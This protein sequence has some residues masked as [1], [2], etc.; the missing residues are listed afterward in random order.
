MDGEAGRVE[1]S[2]RD[3][4]SHRPPTVAV[5]SP[6]TGGFYFGGILTGIAREVAASGGRVVLLQTLDAGRSGDE[7]LG[8]PDFSTPSA[9]DH[10][11]GVIALAASVR[12]PF[13]EDLRARGLAVVT[14]GH[15]VEGFPARSAMPD[16]A[17]GVRAAVE[18]LVRAHGHTRIGF[19]G[20]LEQTD[21]IE[22]FTA[23]Q[24]TLR[25]HGIEPDPDHYFPASN[26]AEEGGRSAAQQ[27]VAAGAPVTAV[28]VATDRNALGLLSVLRDSTDDAVRGL[29][30]V[31][32]DD[33]EAWSTT[34]PGL[35]TVDQEFAHVG[36]VAARVLLA[37]LRGE[38]LPPGRQV[39]PARLVVRTSCGCPPPGT[40][41]PDGHV[42][43]GVPVPGEPA[44]APLP[45]RDRLL[46]RLHE[47]VAP[48]RDTFEA[49]RE[50]EAGA[51]A[52]ARALDAALAEDE[53]AVAAALDEAVS[54]LHAL[55]PTPEALQRTVATV[56]DHVEELLDD[57]A[58]G[59]DAAAQRALRGVV[60]RATSAFWVAHTAARMERAAVLEDTIAEQY[61]VGM[62]LLDRR[63]VDPRSLHW[64]ASTAVRL[65]CLAVWEGT[66]G[67]SP[68]R[69]TGVYDPAGS[70]SGSPGLVGTLLPV[71][72]FPTQEMVGLPDAA[73][74][75]AMFVIPVRAGDTD[76]GVL[77]V[78]GWIDA[79]SMDAR[80]SY[81][82]WA[83]LLAVAFEQERLLEQ[84]LASEERYAVAARATDDGLWEWD[85]RRG[86]TYYSARCLQMLG[87][88]ADAGGTDV[89]F[90]GVHPE[91]RERARRV[92]SPDRSEDWPVELELRM[93]SAA[94]P[95]RWVHCRAI[96]VSEPGQPT[97]R[98]VGSLS[99]IHERKVLEE[100]LRR[101]AL[102]D[103]LTGLPNRALLVERLAEALAAAPDDPADEG[104]GVTVLFLDLDGFKGVNDTHGHAAGDT[105]L[106]AV[107]DRLRHAVRAD[108]TAA[109][110]G[111]DEFVVLLHTRALPTVLS[112]VDRI[113]RAIAH[114]VALPGGAVTVTATVGVAVARPGQ[115]TGDDV[116]RDADNAMYRA[117][118]AR[119]GS[120]ALHEDR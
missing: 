94:G 62:S 45:A 3:D 87:C 1:R 60:L 104:E 42:A 5:L 44:A 18:H 86:T 119:R 110:L 14:A 39:S 111:G 69:I 27:I 106:V 67:S 6:V 58:G 48:D 36:A 93:R 2:G 73:G 113:Q 13:L 117:K 9:M 96:A 11:D 8:A 88:E 28:V 32:F 59:L 102:H 76:W 103:P 82:H 23:Y 90:D 31:G 30:V 81:N 34:H 105:L 85:L 7:A 65:G 97:H 53:E 22:R 38:E 35:T 54:R 4:G 118:A 10:V 70:L 16:N 40:L 51:D 57:P 15:Q 72:G 92:L 25:A 43:P 66:P 68:L 50:L 17:G 56:C 20:C 71:T 84:V 12:R 95:Y 100:Q 91:D 116:L 89:L 52:L 26:N 120:W 37:E 46:G 21:M 98:I 83:A 24:D 107:A 29:A 74:G 47:A 64:M 109:R 75:E 108:D 55:S 79:S 115:A 112:I 49:Q 61:A 78:V 19:V 101:S 114:P 80:A 33:V 99:D 41:R 63:G 77:A